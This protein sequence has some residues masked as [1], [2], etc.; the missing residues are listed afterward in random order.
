MVT[1]LMEAVYADSATQD[2]KLVNPDLISRVRALEHHIDEIKRGMNQVG[3]T[4]ELSQQA[5]RF[6]EKWN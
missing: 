5:E 1:P 6:V 2:L 4:D 3:S